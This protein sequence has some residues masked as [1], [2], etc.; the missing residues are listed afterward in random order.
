MNLDLGLLFSAGV[1]YLLSLFLLA[2]LTDNEIIPERWAAHPA[3]Y[4]LSIGSYATSWTYYGSVGFAAENG[5]R[6]LAIYLGV[7][8]AFVLTPILLRPILRLVNEYQLSSLADLFAFRYRSQAAG[9]LVTLF[10]LL[11]A[12]PYIA[13]QVRAVSTSLSI[14]TQEAPPHLLA[15]GFC[16]TLTLFAV[17]FGARHISPRDKHKGLVVAIAFESLIK[18]VALLSL[19]L[20]AYFGVFGGGSELNTWLVNNPEVLKALYQPVME[21]GW[22]TLIFLSFAAAFL[23][24]RQFHMI[25]SE[26]IKTDGLDT[27]SWLFPLYLLVLNLPIPILLWAGDYLQ[28]DM[29]PEYYVLGIALAQDYPSLALLA[30]IGGL[31]A[32]SAMVIVTSLAL[33]RMSLNHLVLP[34]MMGD[35]RD[36]LYKGVLWIK[37]VLIGLVIGAGYLFYALLQHEEGLVQLGLISFVAV[38]QFIPGI[39]G[40]LYWRRATRPAFVAGLLGGIL[41]WAMLL[42]V[43]LLEMS[44]FV[45]T[46]GQIEQVQ[47]LSGLDKW[48]FATFVSLAVN[49][50]LF[51]LVSLMTEPSD[52]ELA[53]AQSCCSQ[54]FVPLMG[55]VTARSP[56]EF[57]Q[58]LAGML[59]EDTAHKEVQQALSD[60][61]LDSSE[62]RPIE[63][64]R[65]RERL[66][67]NLSGL[68][69]P[70]L[71]HII[72]S[73]RLMLDGQTTTALAD[74]MR[75]VEDRLETSQSLLDG[76]TVELDK[77]RRY[78]R[79]ILMELPLGVCAFSHDRQVVLWNHAMAKL[80]QVDSSLAAG[81]SLPELIEP[82]QQ[83]LGGF[84]QSTDQHVHGLDIEVLGKTRRL[85]L[86]KAR[87]FEP[88]VSQQESSD[89]QPGYVVLIEDVT[90]L[91]TLETELAHS[92]RLAS[93][94]RLAA[95]IA[96]EIGNPVAGVASLA[97]NLRDETDPLLVRE[98]AEEVLEL[99]Q[100]IMRI[101]R[102][103]MDFSRAG[104]DQLH[105]EKIGVLA[106]LEDAVSLARLAYKEKQLRITLVDNG[107]LM[108]EADQQMLAQAFVNLLSNAGDAAP[109]GSE[110]KVTA[111]R[112]GNQVVVTVVDEGPGIPESLRDTLFEPFQ[113]SKPTGSG[114]G[115][116]LSLARKFISDH[117]GSI[118]I[119]SSAISG[120]C[121][122]VSLPLATHT[123]T[124]N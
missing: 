120:T 36:N 91:Q 21:H 69:G 64:R 92:D 5:Y 42:L 114:T 50:G 2:Y 106:I 52:G 117:G 118:T 108:I 98:S 97:Q 54:A 39:F 110:I 67:R 84:L 22:F 45:T 19:G 66:E 121:V 68:L 25:F 17:L 9:V 20:F 8:L 111:S 48:G 77:L 86:H 93:V 59:G 35:L 43:P 72:I 99:T 30:Y 40:V 70:Q 71:A 60:L 11:G 101:V 96:H 3:I 90:H 65:L 105:L 115:L 7:T 112:K 119:D 74:S 58:Q 44:G 38:A 41:V 23:L 122:T 24:P 47:Q 10:M 102:S 79:Q 124:N 26:N 28:L 78:Q 103:L 83:L 73:Q 75:Y 12:L 104:T 53:A 57:E 34:M 16:V 85:N 80:S 88:D 15:L 100:R 89:I 1:A 81:R 6:Y 61:G 63:L 14:L 51:V 116:G 32:A 18:L 29:N 87:F 4:A 76:L 82:W 95:G 46:T 27:A 37:R 113:T 49:G 56:L 33:A 94:G 31:S 13:L 107:P 109:V 55:V 123:A 62:D